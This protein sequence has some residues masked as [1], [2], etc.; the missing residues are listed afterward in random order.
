MK[1]PPC[2]YKLGPNLVAMSSSSSLSESSYMFFTISSMPIRRKSPMEASIP[3]A[4]WQK[5]SPALEN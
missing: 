2:M 4:I 1:I 3:H 5:V